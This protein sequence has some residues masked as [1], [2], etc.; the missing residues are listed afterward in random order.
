MPATSAVIARDPCSQTRVGGSTGPLVVPP[1]EGTTIRTATRR[2]LEVAEELG[3]VSVALPAFGTGVGGFPVGDCA[4]IM[5]RAF[6]EHAAGSLTLV[7]YVLF[8]QSAYDAVINVS[9][10][11]SLPGGAAG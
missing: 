10:Q 3:A 6:R 7:R 4:R 2:T 5:L 8:G 9:R 11:G 1:P